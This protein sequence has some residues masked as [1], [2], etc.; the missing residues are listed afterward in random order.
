M[1]KPHSVRSASSAACL[2]PAAGACRDFLPWNYGITQSAFFIFFIPYESQKPHFHQAVQ[3]MKK[4]RLSR[5]L[6]S[7]IC[8][9]AKPPKVAQSI[10]FEE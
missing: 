6:A 5:T 10:E 8:G 2:L 7:T 9:R 3:Q 1:N 4:P